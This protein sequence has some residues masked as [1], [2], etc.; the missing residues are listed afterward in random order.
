MP[1]P[2]EDILEAQRLHDEAV[3]RAQLFFATIAAEMRRPSFGDMAKSVLGPVLL[4][5][6]EANLYTPEAT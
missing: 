5:A 3:Q 6:Q 4:R 1:T 2:H